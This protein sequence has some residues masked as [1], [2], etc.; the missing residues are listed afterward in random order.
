MLSGN[1]QLDFWTDYKSFLFNKVMYQQKLYHGNYEEKE[2]RFWAEKLLHHL[3]CAT[4]ATRANLSGRLAV[5]MSHVGIE[6]Y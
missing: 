6:S 5:N 2:I 4:V 3:H 1:W